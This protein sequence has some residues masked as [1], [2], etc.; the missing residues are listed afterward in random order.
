MRRI[1][2][3]LTL[4]LLIGGGI[5]YFFIRPNSDTTGNPITNVFE[6]FF[7]NDSSLIPPDGIITETAAPQTD[8][9]KRFTQVTPRPIAGYSIFALS[10][11]L[12]TPNPEQPLKPIISTITD[13]YIRYVSRANGYVYEIKNTEPSV[14]VSNI[15]IPNIYEAVF[16]NSNTTAILR[17]L[18][19]DTQTIATYSVPIPPLNP[20]GTRTQK[21][22]V[23]LPDNIDSLV[24]S[25]DSTVIARLTT[26]AAGGV[27]STS[28][29]S[30]TI[31]KDLIRTP[32]KEWLLQWP[33]QNTVYVQ[34]KA[35]STVNGF[36][37]K[38]DSAAG[39]LRR[40]LGD[41]PGLTTSISPTGAY[42][43]YSQSNGTGFSTK[44]FN[45]TTGTVT[46]ISLSI[47][48]EKCVWYSNSDILCAGNNSVTQ[49]IYPDS[50]YAGLSHFQDQLYRINT[51]TNTY[52]VL[53]DGSQQSFDMT[54]LSLD[55]GQNLLYFIDKSSGLLWKFDL[56]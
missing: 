49:A 8:T 14:Q 53:F 2:I 54:N 52:S 11:T 20:D 16:A 34:S 27:I 45:T 10:K 46:T 24:V 55:E 39:R 1:F 32:F 28:T 6:S 17:F 31:K 30:N 47:L 51:S 13:H 23:Y 41:I 5:W 37:Y 56:N 18:K 3:F 4:F 50:W 42:V 33:T 35:S 43:L 40:V 44:L 26:E 38:I 22:G 29:A 25:P 12:T 19:P 36:L 21:A 48:P 15:L 7:P 9:R